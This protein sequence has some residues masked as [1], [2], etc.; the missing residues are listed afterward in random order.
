MSRTVT[1]VGP[2]IRVGIADGDVRGGDNRSIQL[3]IDALPPD[4][5]TIEILPGV[6][7]CFDALHLKSG[8]RLIGHGDQTVLLKCDGARSPLKIDADYGQLKITPVDASGFLPGMG[9]LVGDNRTGGWL[10][11]A[12]TVLDVRD[13][14]LTIADYL[15]M[16]YAARREGWVSSACSL[17]S[18]IDVEDV[19]IENLTVDG[20]KDANSQMNGCR[21][22]AIY[23][24]KARR[25]SLHGCSVRDYNGDGI[26]I[27]ITE[28]TAIADC[29]VHGCTHIGMH[30]GTGS[31]RVRMKNCTF[32]DNGE[33][34]FFLCWRVQ[35]ST[36][37]D[38]LCERNGVY[39]ISVGHKDTDN[40]F[41]RCVLRDNGQYGV[42]FRDEE[43]YNGGHRNTWQECLIENNGNEQAGIGVRVR[44][45]THDN[46]FE[47]CTFRDTRPAGAVRQRVGMWL[48]SNTRRFRTVHCTWNG[49]IDNLVD[50][51]GTAGEHEIDAPQGRSHPGTVPR[52]EQRP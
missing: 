1:R 19:C 14:V 43:L 46:T 45:H 34:G 36:F 4:G 2:T 40:A 6:Y 51:A 9:L 3:A 28:D 35:E 5:G 47:D 38:L 39:G 24:H 41:I 26:S 44:G 23:L 27:Q 17:I 50:E 11:T 48:E 33:G 16:D 21:G 20:N 22:G 25:C 32:S 49:M 15:V 29:Q 7:T 42:V 37:Q 31:A 18:G 12:T 8:V 10:E 52:P 30:P 13:G